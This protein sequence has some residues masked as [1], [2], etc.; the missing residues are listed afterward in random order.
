V[1]NDTDF[2]LAS[3]RTIRLLALDQS[4][5]YEGLLLGM[6]TREMN[7]KLMDRLIATYVHPAEYG[8]PLLLDPEQRPLAV[9]D[10]TPHHGAPTALPSVT[11]V[12]RFISGALAETDDIWSVL[13]V[14]WFQDDFAFPIGARALTQIADID[15]EMHA[16]SWEP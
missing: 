11:C 1:A 8:V 13:R 4:F 5:T 7:Q 9:P 14:I 10:H 12:A 15:W 16:T 3:G 6:P 2:T